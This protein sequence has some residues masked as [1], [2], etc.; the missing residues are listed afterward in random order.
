MNTV[1]YLYRNILIMLNINTHIG[2][3]KYYAEPPKNS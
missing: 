3:H 1:Y 2:Y